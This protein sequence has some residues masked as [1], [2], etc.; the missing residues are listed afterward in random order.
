[1]D[2]ESLEAVV[3]TGPRLHSAFTATEA[4]ITKEALLRQIPPD[5]LQ[6]ALAAE[7]SSRKDRQWTEKEAKDFLVQYFARDQH[8]FDSWPK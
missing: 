5:L 3:F 1:M 6:D 4:R 8:P 7:V 2:I